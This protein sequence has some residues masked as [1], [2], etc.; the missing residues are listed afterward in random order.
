MGSLWQYTQEIVAEFNK[1]IEVGTEGRIKTEWLYKG[2]HPY[3]QADM[4]RALEAGV[5]DFTCHSGEIGGD[6]PV[7]R[8]INVTGMPF[9]IPGGNYEYCKELSFWLKDE[10]IFD[11]I[12]EKW[13]G[14]MVLNYYSGGQH[15]FMKDIRITGPDSLKG[16][17]VRVPGEY[18]AHIIRV[19]GGEP[20][21]VDWGEVYTAL[22]TGLCDGFQSSF[23][24]SLGMGYIE[25][26]PYITWLNM[27]YG[28]QSMVANQDSL[29]ALSPDVRDAL[30]RTLSDLEDWFCDGDVKATLGVLERALFDLNL[31]IS[32]IP[33]DWRAEIRAQ[34]FES[35]WKPEIEA[36]GEKGWELFDRIAK[37]LIADGY[38]VPGYT[39]R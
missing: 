31:N 35:G 22:A 2:E 33:Q 16:K 26:T 38:D 19:M 30:F 28:Q 1:R 29:A 17:K 20:V 23:V 7:Y 14:K 39:P 6:E 9:L 10:G 15:I 27:C 18:R 37:K 11:E 4:L 32:T 36:G 8:A 25:L 21:F 5:C 3:A 13:N 34:M 24:A 12:Y